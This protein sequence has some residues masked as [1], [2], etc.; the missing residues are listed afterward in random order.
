MTLPNNQSNNLSAEEILGIMGDLY[1]VRVHLEAELRATLTR[2]AELE[3]HVAF[4][5]EAQEAT[6]LSNAGT[7]R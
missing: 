1:R 7:A 3:A 2:V 4:L 6:P 5:E